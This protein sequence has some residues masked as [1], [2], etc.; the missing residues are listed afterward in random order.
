[1]AHDSNTYFDNGSEYDCLTG[2]LTPHLIIV[3]VSART[4]RNIEGPGNLAHRLDSH[5]AP[6]ARMSFRPTKIAVLLARPRC[7][8]S[9]R[10]PAPD[11]AALP[12]GSRWPRGRTYM[13]LASNRISSLR[14]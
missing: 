3:A 7:L 8:S 13:S 14:T 11:T 12:R 5:A 9:N 10:L 2:R 1:M 4:M 6:G